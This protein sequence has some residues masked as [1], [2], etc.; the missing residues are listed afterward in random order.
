MLS[1]TKSALGAVGAAAEGGNQKPAED[2][3]APIIADDRADHSRWLP[4]GLLRLAVGPQMR[5]S[6]VHKIAEFEQAQSGRSLLHKTVGGV[7]LVHPELSYAVERWY[8]DQDTLLAWY[9]P[10]A[11]PRPADA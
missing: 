8:R 9:T 6:T 3:V 5:D 7:V 1:E 2:S 11:G 10:S 4:L